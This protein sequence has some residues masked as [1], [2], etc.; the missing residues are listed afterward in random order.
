MQKVVF[1][2]RLKDA[3]VFDKSFLHIIVEKGLG[4]EAEKIFGII[5]YL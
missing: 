4:G 3:L 1:M 5:F 2:G